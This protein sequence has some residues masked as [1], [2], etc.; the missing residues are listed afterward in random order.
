[1]K[2]YQAILFDLYDTLIDL[3]IERFPLVRIG[4]LERRTTSGL[5]YRA[6]QEHYHQ[7]GFDEFF[8]AFVATYREVDALKRQEHR[9]ILAADRFGVLLTRLGIQSPVP[10]FVETLVNI[11]MDAMFGVMEF[12]SSR[13]SL[14]ETLR[15]S[16][17]LG[18][19]SNFDHP[20]TARRVLRHY[21][22]DPYFGVVI[23][24][25]DI[26]WR[27]PRR[28]I[29]SLAL[30][31]L[32]VQPDESL[33]VGDTPYADIVGAKQ[34]GMDVVWLDHGVAELDPM[35]PHPDYIIHEME[36]LR[37]ILPED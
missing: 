25:G 36:E 12:P 26:G 34:V 10:S 8:Q 4:D 20:P 14:L 13:R 32:G 33:F 7:I 31:A 23:I 37:L 17:R 15:T 16:Y 22:L 2:R 21:D 1:M 5:V 24:S 6:F 18:I 30:G 28:E 19:V 9:E 35:G 11:H 29:F 3:N 27:K